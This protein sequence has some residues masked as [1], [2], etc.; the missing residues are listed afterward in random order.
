MKPYWDL[1]ELTIKRILGII[2]KCEE[3]ELENACFIY[4]PKLKN[5]VKFYMVKYDH[6][7]N[8]TVIQNLEK[9][10]DIYKFKDRSLTFEY[11]QHN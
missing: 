6:H 4:N 5:E 7:W 9:K 11:S 2:E 1:D 8:L 3:L 10:S